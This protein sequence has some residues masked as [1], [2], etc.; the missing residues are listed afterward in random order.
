[1]EL[2]GSLTYV[3]TKEINK[4]PKRG[5]EEYKSRLEVLIIFH[6]KAKEEGGPLAK[7]NDNTS[8]FSKPLAT[9]VLGT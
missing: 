2:I 3:Y 8:T 6:Q 4:P 9:E 7:D 5:R 1:M